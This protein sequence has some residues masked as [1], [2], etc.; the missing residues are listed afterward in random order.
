[1][2]DS[3]TRYYLTRCRSIA[4][5]QARENS[6]AQGIL[7]EDPQREE[8]IEAIYARVST[9]KHLDHLERQIQGLKTAYHTAVVFRDCAS[10]LNFC[11]KGLLSFLQRVLAGGVRVV[12]VAYR[13]RLCRF[14]Y[15]L[16]ERVFNHFGTTIAVESDDASSPEHELAEDVLAIIAVFSARMYGRRSGSARGGGR[17]IGRQHI[18]Y[19][20]Q[21]GEDR[22]SG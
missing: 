19:E 3:G 5:E 14:A 11:R 9:R 7:L 15:D 12:R 10:G 8:G 18:R 22:P 4:T 21:A 20:A 1:M 16:I 6:D 17:V 2:F 13:D